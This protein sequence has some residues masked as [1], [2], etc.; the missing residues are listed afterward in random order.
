[1]V[2]GMSKSPSGDMRWSAH[3]PSIWL[4]A[5]TGCDAAKIATAAQAVST[6]LLN[7]SSGDGGRAFRRSGSVPW[8]L[9]SVPEEPNARRGISSYFDATHPCN[10]GS[11]RELHRFAVRR[12]RPRQD[13]ASAPPPGIGRARIAGACRGPE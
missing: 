10:G 4:W 7:G 6:E 11:A 3:D 12:V 2:R 1:M 13:D 8:P 9:P 5:E